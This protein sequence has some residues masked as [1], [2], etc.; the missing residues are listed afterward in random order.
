[1]EEVDPGSK[2]ESHL[3]VASPGGLVLLLSVGA[4]T[5]YHKLNG[6]KQ[7]KCITLQFSRS[8][9]QNG[10][11][12]ARI[13]VL[14][15]LQSLW[16]LLWTVCFFMFSSFASLIAQLVKNLPAM[17]ETPVRFLGPENPLEKG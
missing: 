6:L 11:Y 16:K 9:V 5:D 13:K 1:M 8:E 2:V 15:G 3:Y 14:A 7:H 12:W 10:F 4:V 17:Q